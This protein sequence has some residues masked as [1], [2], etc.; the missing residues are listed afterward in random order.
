M[1]NVETKEVNGYMHADIPLSVK[2]WLAL[3]LDADTPKNYIDTLLKFYYEPEHE[4]SCK[5]VS[6][7]YGILS[8]T[9]NAN[10]MHFG[11][12]IQSHY[13]FSIVDEDG[14]KRYWL[15][16]MDGKQDGKWFVYKVK[17][18]LCDAI[19][20][21]LYIHLEQTYKNYRKVVPIIGEY[22]GEKWDELYKWKLITDCQQKDLLEQ[23][24]LWRD[25]NLYYTAGDR[26]VVNDMID[27]HTAEYKRILSSLCQD[28][29]NLTSRLES[30]RNEMKKIVDPKLSSKANDERIAS[31]ILSCH[32]PQLYTFYKSEVYD[33]LCNYL[34]IKSEQRISYKFP[35]F[36]EIIKPLRK[37]VASDAELK[38]IVSPYLKGQLQSDLLLAQDICWCLMRMSKGFLDLP[39]KKVEKEKLWIVKVKYQGGIENFRKNGYI[40]MGDSAQNLT[41]SKYS[42]WS[43][44]K[45]DFQKAVPN[46]NNTIPQAYW[47]LMH[48]V[49]QGDKVIAVESGHEKD[50]HYFSWLLGWGTLSGEC[51]YEEENPP[52][53]MKVTWHEPAPVSPI[54]DE[55]LKN[56]L[57]FYK[58]EDQDT[59]IRIKQLLDI[60]KSDNGKEMDSQYN[61]YIDL[62]KSNHNLILTGAPGTGKTYLAKHIAATMIGCKP[63]ELAQS[64]HFGF[65]QFHPSYDYTDFVEGLRPVDKEGEGDQIGFERK[66]GIFKSF[67]E[68]ALNSQNPNSFATVYS[69]LIN[70]IREAEDG[71]FTIQ[72]RNGSKSQ[73]LIVT[74]N[75]NIKWQLK[76]GVHSVNTVSKKRLYKLYQKYPTLHDTE[77]VSNM[78]DAVK[79]VIGG[80]D[81]TY[82]WAVLIEILSR[83]KNPSEPIPF[84]FVIDEIN[85]GE[86]SKIF[87]ELFFSID[88]GYRGKS[89]AVR[90]QYSNLQSSPNS[91]DIALDTK[92]YGNFFVPENVYIIGTM[93]DIDRSVES[94]DFAMRRRFVWEEVTAEESMEMLTS[95]NEALGDIDD[96]TIEE[97]RNRML[98]LNNAIIGKYGKEGN[99]ARSMR[100]G[101]AYQIGGSYF[102]KFAQYYKSGKE[103]AFEKLWNNHIKNVL[104][105]YLR[106]NTNIV[107]QMEYLKAAYDDGTVHD[108]DVNE[109][110]VG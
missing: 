82:Y 109:E 67:C 50:G 4:A 89:G 68:K 10:I 103:K 5:K 15:T 8:G 69:D 54:K 105:E 65:V 88:P 59:I 18:E 61:K 16:I 80:C 94:M 28:D 60:D 38:E 40:G 90:T 42:K 84:I 49:K 24:K 64:G 27:N 98:N 87:G 66:D 48:E 41:Y 95:A 3:L 107:E 102:L 29:V 99:A 23:V 56:Q 104:S 22:K 36:L 2:D 19:R 86:I 46:S 55:D 12:Y 110:N 97:L 52:I 26:K 1:Q 25:T 72:L 85:R 93:N 30:F 33:N 62:L 35:H 13:E 21:W 77:N 108:S 58:V 74:E 53:R 47:Q 101:T 17:Q 63:E 92:D 11:Q 37:L 34:G 6:D 79:E 91:F 100:L 20:Q 44:L 45:N 7:D 31:T 81:T 75:D 78:T 51:E 76:D 14:D 96:D 9:A 83:M 70:D 32:N 39:P 43:E 71:N 106:G 57:F 73:P